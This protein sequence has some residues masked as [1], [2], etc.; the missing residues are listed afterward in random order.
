MG[1]SVLIDETNTLIA[2]NGVTKGAKAEGITKVRVIDAEPGEIIAVRR[3]DLTPEQKKRMALFDNRAGELA[4]WDDIVLP[5]LLTEVG[6]DGLFTAEEFDKMLPNPEIEEIDVRKPP[7]MAWVLIGVPSRDF[8]KIQS[9]VAKIEEV[10]QESLQGI[11]V[12]T[13]GTPR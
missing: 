8:V 12:Q 10:A 4:E 7:D 9:L 6:I 1:R 2:G 13:T 11:S 5:E 3:R